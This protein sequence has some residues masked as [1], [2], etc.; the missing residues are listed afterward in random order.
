MPGVSFLCSLVDTHGPRLFRADRRI[1]VVV[2]VLR[3]IDQ[4]IGIGGDIGGQRFAAHVLQIV[5]GF[6]RRMAVA[7]VFLVM[8][9]LAVG[10]V[11]QGAGHRVDAVKVDEE[12]S[13]DRQRRRG[14]DRA[15]GGAAEVLDMAAGNE[16]E[17]IRERNAPEHVAESDE[18]KDRPEERDEFVGVFLERG[19]EDFEAEKFEDRFEEIFCAG[20]SG[21]VGLRK[22][23][24]ENQQHQPAGDQRH[25]ALVGEPCQ[26]FPEHRVGEHMLHRIDGKNRVHAKVP[27]WLRPA[28]VRSKRRS[29]HTS[30]ISD[31]QYPSIS[32]HMKG[33]RTATM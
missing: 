11:H 7:A 17:E 28:V 25:E 8:A 15:G 19:A 10:A 18:E 27:S 14:V 2:I 26:M 22:K 6:M 3:R 21:A 24:G 12:E 29:C 13:A 32:Q 9:V 30:V 4:R 33:I 31:T 5:G 1:F 20:W 23:R 16:L